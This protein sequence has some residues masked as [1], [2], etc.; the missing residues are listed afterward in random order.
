MS[1]EPSLLRSHSPVFVLLI[2]VSIPLIGV[3]FAHEF[4][5]NSETND[6]PDS[7]II[8]DA[9]TP[10]TDVETEAIETEEPVVILPTEWLPSKGN[11]CFNYKG[12]RSC[13]GPRKAPRPHGSA[14]ELA[15][16]LGLGTTKGTVILMRY[17]PNDEQLEAI[18][19][20]ETEEFQWPVDGGKLWRGF[21]KVRKRLKGVN[22]NGIDIGAPV[23]THI[24]A[25]ADG[26]VGYSDNIQPN[27]GNMMVIIHKNGLTTHY[28]HC[29]ANYVFPGQQVKAGQVI[30][31][32]GK[33][34]LTRG[35]HLHFEIRKK[36]VPQ[37]PFGYQLIKQ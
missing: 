28:A 12:R 14:A 29:K 27:Y 18:E 11:E 19:G 24:L 20:Q 13:Q 4:T 10:E 8:A 6:T 21:G 22:H 31:E 15:E 16:K 17:G 9:E 25:A 7:G 3:A 35:A 1:H 33:T 32:V 36:G 5:D 37:D 34:G 23:G 30:G 2:V 26:L